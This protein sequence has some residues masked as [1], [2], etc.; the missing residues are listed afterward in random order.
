MTELK[1]RLKS[2]RK[3]ARMTQAELAKAVPISQ[4]T[5]SDLESGR[6]KN[7]TSLVRIAQV[8]DVSPTWL[9]TGQGQMTTSGIFVAGNNTNNGTQIGTQHRFVQEGQA[10]DDISVCLSDDYQHAVQSLASIANISPSEWV[11]RVVEKE[12]LAIREQARFALQATEGVGG[13]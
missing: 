10:S 2:A 6:N 3:Y 12:I 1:D 7:T 11:S 4:G 9:A 8:L 13:R 5:I